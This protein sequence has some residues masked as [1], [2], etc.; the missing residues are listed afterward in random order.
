MSDSWPGTINLNN[1]KHLKRY[2]QKINA[3]SIVPTKL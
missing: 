3:F 1:T 2:K